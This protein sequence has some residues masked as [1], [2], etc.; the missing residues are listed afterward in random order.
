MNCVEIVR[1]AKGCGFMVA[2]AVDESSTTT[3]DLP[4]E[5]IMM[6]CQCGTMGVVDGKLHH[7]IEDERQ[8]Y[9]AAE[10]WNFAREDRL[11]EGLV[12]AKS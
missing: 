8:R 1:T 5:S 6:C 2:R 4:G 11:P 10:L 7:C 3:G 9:T 12:K